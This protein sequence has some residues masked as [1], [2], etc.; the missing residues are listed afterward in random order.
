MRGNS[1][2]LGHGLIVRVAVMV[3]FAVGVQVVESIDKLSLVIISR[4]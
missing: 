2:V 3:F 1:N 4:F